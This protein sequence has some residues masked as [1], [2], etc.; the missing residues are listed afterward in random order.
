MSPA[1]RCL[2]ALLL[3]A[4]SA[5]LPAVAGPRGDGAAVPSR[6]RRA[7]FDLL[8]RH[9]D[10]APSEDVAF[11]R[12]LYGTLVPIGSGLLMVRGG[13]WLTAIGIP[14]AAAGVIVGPSLGH[15][16]A[17]V[18]GG[19]LFRSLA[20]V[21]ALGAGLAV[22]INESEHGTGAI[23]AGAMVA[24]GV[25]SIVL[26]SMVYDIATVRAKVRRANAAAAPAASLTLRAAP[27]AGA[28]SLAIH[29]SF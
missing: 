17:G 29:A 3:V 10:S 16:Y 25:G 23:A 18:P 2:A 12:S 8:G 28:P 1:A 15:I 6:A 5:P 11:R 24:V 9:R 4:L 21:A 19:V 27:C 7:A 22:G 13:S 14:V 20:T 26:G